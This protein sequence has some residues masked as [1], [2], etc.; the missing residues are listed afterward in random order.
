MRRRTG[1]VP[2]ARRL[3]VEGATRAELLDV[4]TAADLEQDWRTD[5]A[6]GMAPSVVASTRVGSATARDIVRVGAALDR[7][8]H[9]REAF[10]ASH[11]ALGARRRTY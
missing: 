4:V 8:P 9:L 10:A 6:T 1:D 5:G 11:P 7:L 2:R 3:R